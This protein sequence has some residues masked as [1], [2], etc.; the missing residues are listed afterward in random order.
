MKLYRLS[1][2]VSPAKLATVIECLSGEGQNLEVKEVEAPHN[3]RRVR[4]TRSYEGRNNAEVRV[5]GGA[6]AADTRTGKIY[7][8]Y[9]KE[10][11]PAK[12]GQIGDE[13]ARHGF[14]KK[15][16]SPLTSRLQA[17]GKVRRESD[18]KIHLV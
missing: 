6:A 3:R 1:I 17:E 7:L 13:F 18:G 12:I 8:E 15:S 16:A 9:L 10:H 2:D 5:P 11:G 14:N 4:S